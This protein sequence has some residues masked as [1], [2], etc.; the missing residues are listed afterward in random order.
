M[1][2]LTVPSRGLRNETELHLGMKKQI[3]SSLT[4]PLPSVFCPPPLTGVPDILCRPTA[5]IVFDRV[6]IEPMFACRGYRADLA[7]SLARRK[8]YVEVVVTSVVSDE[9]YLFYKEAGYAVVLVD[10]SSRRY[11]VRNKRDRLPK[12]LFTDT[13]GEIHD[14]SVRWLNC[15]LE[16]VY[17]DKMQKIINLFVRYGVKSGL[18][19]ARCMRL[20]RETLLKVST[21]KEFAWEIDGF[22]CMLEKGVRFY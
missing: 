18:S 17:V 10:F 21:F 22:C 12:I 14:A 8:L 9:K 15:P 7:L 4:L 19:S 16:D 5:D 2:V 3:A 11:M 20:V 6:D 1:P 13:N